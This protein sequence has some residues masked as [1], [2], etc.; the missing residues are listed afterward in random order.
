MDPQLDLSILLNIQD[1]WTHIYLKLDLAHI[2]LNMYMSI[3]TYNY[4]CLVQIDIVSQLMHVSNLNKFVTFISNHAF[5]KHGKVC[6]L[7]SLQTFLLYRTTQYSL[8]FHIIKVVR[9]FQSTEALINALHD[10]YVQK[11]FV[12]L[13]LRNKSYQLCIHK[14]F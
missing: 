14:T 8:R 12:I 13:S 9:Y 2:H 5:N 10:C 3:Y 7:I 6:G 1:Y 11:L 4:I